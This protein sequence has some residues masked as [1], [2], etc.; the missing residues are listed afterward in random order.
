MMFLQCGA[1]FSFR[2]RDSS[3]CASEVED[4]FK[5]WSGAYFASKCGCSYASR[6]DSILGSNS[7]YYGY[8]YVP[9]GCLAVYFESKVM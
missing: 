5:S 7:K 8:A 9:E 4:I 6:S 3:R 2:S 1:D